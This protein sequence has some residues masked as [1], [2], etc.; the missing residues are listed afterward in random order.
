V[1]DRLYHINGGVNKLYIIDP[2]TNATLSSH[3]FPDGLLPTAVCTGRSIYEF[4]DYLYIGTTATA[5]SA[6]IIFDHINEQWVHGLASYASSSQ[7]AGYPL[8][9]YPNRGVLYAGAAIQ[10]TASANSY[11]PLGRA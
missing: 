11:I 9:G 6:L 10:G 8:T 4:G 2:A 5:P 1:T 3:D 7:T